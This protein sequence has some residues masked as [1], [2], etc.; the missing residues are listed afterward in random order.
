MCRPK[1]R[2]TVSHPKQAPEMVTEGLLS[3]KNVLSLLLREQWSMGSI[4]VHG[5][6]LS[7]IM[8]WLLVT[9]WWAFNGTLLCDPNYG[10]ILNWI[11]RAYYYLEHIRYPDSRVVRTVMHFFF[12]FFWPFFSS[13]KSILKNIPG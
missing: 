10:G 3:F 8:F 6:P 13:F 7:T 2:K 4:K 1:C 5:V 12:I 9:Q 11:A